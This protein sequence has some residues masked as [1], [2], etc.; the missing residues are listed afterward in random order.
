MKNDLTSRSPPVQF[1]GYR[2]CPLPLSYSGQIWSIRVFI[3]ALIM[4]KTIVSF[5]TLTDLVDSPVGREILR[6]VS[7]KS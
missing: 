6:F 2:S 5:T 1:C 3:S 4:Y 7:V